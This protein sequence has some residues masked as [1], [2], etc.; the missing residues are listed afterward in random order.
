MKKILFTFIF[1]L[2]TGISF[3]TA[4]IFNIYSTELNKKANLKS[5][6]VEIELQEEKK[7]EVKENS[8]E[9]EQE[10]I[11]D[12]S[13]LK[14][15]IQKEKYTNMGTYKITAYC[16]CKK[17]CGKTDGITASG[18]KASENHT[19]AAP[20]NFPFGTKL[21]ING[22]V[23]TVEDRGGAVKNKTLDIYF[24]SHQEA[25]DY[26]VQYHEVFLINY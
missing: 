16:N 10:V 6:I 5:N 2:L 15:P 19:I 25:L 26:G 9:E 23:Y 13:Q 14:E 20:S 11:I 7:E 17:C 3:L 1:L 22:I 4:K 12:D 8:Y 21:L 18:V 24:D